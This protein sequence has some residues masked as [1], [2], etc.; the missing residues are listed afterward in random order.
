[1][2]GLNEA[3]QH[4]LNERRMRAYRLERVQKELVK[5]EYAAA[6]LFDPIN[7]RYA[8]GSSNMQVW[9]LHNAAR[10]AFVPAEGK[11]LLFETHGCRHLPLGIETIEEIRP[12][13]PWF[14]FGAGPRSAETVKLWASEIADLVKRVGARNRR[15]AV[16]KCDPPGTFELTSLG[17]SLHDG[18]EVLEHAR[19]VKSTDEIEAI[20]RAIS[21]CEAGMREMQRVA[22]PGLTENQVWALLHKV[23]IEHG[24]EWIETRLLT[25]GPRTNPWMQECSSRVIQNGDLLCFDTDLIGPNGYLADVSRTWLM[26]ERPATDDQRR[27]YGMAC[28][29]MR[30]NTDLLKPG[31]GFREFMERAWKIPDLYAPNRYAII[32]HGAGMCDEYPA[33]PYPHDFD[34]VGYDGIFQEGM[35]LCVESYVG[36]LGGREGV[37]LEQQVL[38]TSNGCEELSSYP[39]EE[40]LL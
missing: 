38:I 21:V 24:G 28:E 11:V 36:A 18:Q 40:R 33:V 39:L 20:R 12:A 17:L 14:F 8:T 30:F 16:D 32:V 10:Y 3:T 2:S 23:N 15:L 22:E 29:Q 13:I 27:L 1:M 37:K 6:L 25:S 4:S 35:V 9:T 5:R 26:G 7:I 34:K 31:L 19:A